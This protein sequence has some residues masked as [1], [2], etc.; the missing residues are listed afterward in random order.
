MTVNGLSFEPPL[1][2]EL[3]MYQ[4]RKFRDFD[5]KAFSGADLLYNY[6]AVVEEL[7]RARPASAKGRYFRKVTISPTMGPGVRLVPPS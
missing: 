2:W 6:N 7:E 1:F 3:Y 4:K 5:F